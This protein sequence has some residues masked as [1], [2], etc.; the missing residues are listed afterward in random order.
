MGI[1]TIPIRATITFG[2]YSVSTPYILSFNVNKTRTAVSTFSASVKVK[3]SSLPSIKGTVVIK[4]GV[5][6]GMRT[7]FTGYV[8]TVQP[9]PCWDDP[10]YVTVSVSGVDELHKLENRRF[11][12]RQIKTEQL[13][14]VITGISQEGPTP[15]KLKYTGQ[16]PLMTTSIKDRLSTD[17]GGTQEKGKRDN[18]IVTPPIK[19][20]AK[21]K[22]PNQPII[23]TIGVLEET[24]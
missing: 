8:K 16:A 6:G 9:S 13:Y 3:Y 18:D 4:A 11:T 19:D 17:F 22:K 15:S 24:T 5:K 7:I 14:A 10:S 20:E 12:R 2:A 21:V 23:G 1:E